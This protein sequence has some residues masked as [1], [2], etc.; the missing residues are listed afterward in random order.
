M[1]NDSLTDSR[2]PLPR[3]VDTMEDTIP[4]RPASAQ[5]PFVDPNLAQKVA[6][7]QQRLGNLDF[8]K[9]VM[10]NQVLVVTFIRPNQ[11][12]LAG[13]GTIHFADKTLEEDKYQGKVGLVVQVGP[14]AFQDDKEYTFNGQ[15]AGVGDWVVYRISDGMPLAIRGVHCRLIR[16]SEVKMVISEP[17]AIL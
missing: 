3:L 12:Q 11:K 13:G 14:I 1:S 7:L 16:D 2:H 15:S 4:P 17:T 10:G 6:E 5:P 9:H 8:I